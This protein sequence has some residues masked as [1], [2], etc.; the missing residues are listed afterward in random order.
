MKIG[1]GIDV[2][3]YKAAY[4]ALFF[5]VPNRGIVIDYLRAMVKGQ[6]NA[7]LVENLAPGSPYLKDLHALF[8]H[9]F[10]YSNSKIVSFYETVESPTPI[11]ASLVQISCQHPLILCAGRRPMGPK[12]SRGLT[13]RQGIC[14]F[15]SSART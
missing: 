12:G 15:K 8:C 1:Q 14:Y 7:E 6:P 3:N 10:V 5:G 11:L 4:A 9:R 13:S 2:R